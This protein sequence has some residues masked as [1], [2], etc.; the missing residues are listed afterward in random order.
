MRHCPV[1]G[2]RLAAVPHLSHRK[3][4]NQVNLTNNPSSPFFQ[5][6]KKLQHTF[7]GFLVPSHSC[8][9]SSYIRTRN[10][11]PANDQSIQIVAIIL[12]GM[13][14]VL[15]RLGSAIMR[16]FEAGGP[17]D[18]LSSI[19]NHISLWCTDVGTPHSGTSL[20]GNKIFYG[21]DWSSLTANY[22]KQWSMKDGV[23]RAR[24]AAGRYERCPKYIRYP[25]V[26]LRSGDRGWA[27][28]IPYLMS[29][30]VQTDAPSICTGC[31][32]LYYLS[33]GS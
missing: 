12:T 14:T 3:E 23:R 1:T 5:L 29:H 27:T 33:K 26:P 22:A 28:T 7:T 21:S 2:H 19:L 9:S 6:P 13:R 32:V 31:K 17:Q 8:I 24:P 10:R 18:F 11:L 20:W 16:Q 15:T 25:A 4:K 30:G